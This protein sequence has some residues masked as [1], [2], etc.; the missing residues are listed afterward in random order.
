MDDGASSFSLTKRHDLESAAS[1][2]DEGNVVADTTR[3]TVTQNGN[4][5]ETLPDDV[6]ACVLEYSVFSDISKLAKAFPSL[7][8]NSIP[9]SRLLYLDI[10]LDCEQDLT[11]LGFDFE[12]VQEVVIDCL[13]LVMPCEAFAYS[14][15]T[16]GFVQNYFEILVFLT[17]L[18]NLKHVFI[19][20]G[21]N[22]T[23]QD[24]LERLCLSKSDNITGYSYNGH[25]RLELHPLCSS[26]GK[27]SA[28][29]YSRF[30]KTICRAYSSGKLS[31]EVLFHGLP[32]SH[33][34]QRRFQQGLGGLLDRS[35]TGI[36]KGDN[37]RVCRLICHTF[38]QA[39]VALL[40]NGT[41]SHYFPLA[42]GSASLGKRREWIS[43]QEF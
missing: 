23:K 31:K 42:L 38:P 24:I 7:L 4:G 18:K 1:A 9:L 32:A 19:G 11:S 12:S 39:Q 35:S 26:G 28:R 41:E 40:K 13:F 25:N 2:A 34:Y 37:C 6:V 29:E 17:S 3:E 21:E 16:F 27:H 5:L 10:A 20:R 30:L 15:G 43:E 33:T 8:S 22:E 14:K 36:C